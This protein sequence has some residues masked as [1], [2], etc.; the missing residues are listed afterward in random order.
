LWELT[1]SKYEEINPYII[2]SSIFSLYN[3]TAGVSYWLY[4]IKNVTKFLLKKL[5]LFKDWA[6]NKIVT[7][8]SGDDSISVHVQVLQLTKASPS[9]IFHNYYS[10]MSDGSSF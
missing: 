3:V 6:S 1:G 9:I 5:S 4:R 10:F 7:P 2:I 8:E